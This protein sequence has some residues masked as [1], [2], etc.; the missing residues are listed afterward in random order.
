MRFVA[1]RGAVAELLAGAPWRSC[2]LGRCGEKPSGRCCWPGAPQWQRYCWPGRR[3]RA[4]AERRRY[5][6]AF[7]GQGYRGGKPSG[8]FCWAGRRG[9]AA[10]RECHGEEDGGT[11]AESHRE[12][13]AGQGAAAELHR[14]AATAGKV[15]RA[16]A[17]KKGL[18]GATGWSLFLMR[19]LCKLF[20]YL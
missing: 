20:L 7:A 5:G 4:S 15:R 12:A 10:G 19:P 6:G 16:T 2:W 18:Q 9:G 3:G 14:E 1:G 11:V 8:S 17:G 13:F